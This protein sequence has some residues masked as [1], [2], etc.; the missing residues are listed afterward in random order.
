M[1]TVTP[2]PRWSEEETLQREID[3]RRQLELDRRARI[4][5]AK[6][7]TIG[8]DKDA[9]DMQVL[10]NQRRREAEKAEKQAH[11][12][13]L[14][15]VGKHLKLLDMD[16]QRTRRDMEKATK[17]HFDPM[18]L[19]FDSKVQPARCG[20]DDP[21]CGPSSMQ[22]FAGEDLMREERIR[23]QQLAQVNF[24]EQQKFEKALLARTDR[25]AERA[26]AEEVKNMT[27]ARNAM[28]DTEASVRRELQK[29]LNDDH[30]QKALEACKARAR[31]R[32][33]NSDQNAIELTH[34]STDNFLNEKTPYCNSNGRVRIDAYKGSAQ[35]ERVQVAQ[36]QQDQI[37]EKK[38]TKD[39]EKHA[40]QQFAKQVEQTRRQLLAIEREK[41][42]A[43]RGMIEQ[44]AQANMAL[45]SEQKQANKCLNE[46]NKNE[47]LPEFFD[48][49]GKTTR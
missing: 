46:K 28:E 14:L 27:A 26:F 42:R 33:V 20:D 35:H 6:R 17:S 9:L 30:Y 37:T 43:R 7:R 36:Q 32:E 1:M 49:F 16:Q 22:Q 48:Q 13:N 4:F 38:K 2:K 47:Y 12:A 44:M 10:E 5:D 18:A 25:D 11:D 8:I 39:F 15:Q 24:I 34:H 31:E 3:R 23:Q 19:K 45:A 29:S 40:C 41:Q 21:R